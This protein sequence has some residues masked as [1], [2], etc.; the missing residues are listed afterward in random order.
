MNAVFLFERR[1]PMKEIAKAACLF[2]LLGILILPDV[3]FAGPPA[4]VTGTLTY[5][6]GLPGNRTYRFDYA[7]ENISLQ[8]YIWGFIVFFNEDGLDH[9][10]F[11]SYAYPTGW[12]IVSILPEDPEGGPWS[13]EWDGG[14]EHPNPILPGQTLTGFSVTF[15]WKDLQ[16][17]PGPQIY[18]VW[19]TEA[20]DG[21]T[22]VVNSGPTGL[23]KTSWGR[24]KSMF[25]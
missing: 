20:Y 21:I 5:V 13:V 6:E 24:I 4:V 15:I 25:K 9:S 11:V 18:E 17:C 1:V 16:V 10:D 22:T 23:E 2:F 14:Y 7:V 19:N 3:A 8:P 12:E